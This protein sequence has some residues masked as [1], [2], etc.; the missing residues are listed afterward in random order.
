MSEDIDGS[1]SVLLESLLGDLH[2]ADDPPTEPGERI[3][4]DFHDTP[5]QKDEERRLR[6]AY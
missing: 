2:R 5:L 6:I 4:A 3:D 1:L